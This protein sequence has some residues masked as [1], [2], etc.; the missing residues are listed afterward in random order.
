[1]EPADVLQLFWRLREANV[2]M[3]GRLN[4]EEW[5]RFGWH[6]ERGMITVR[7]LMLHMAGHDTNH[8]NQIRAILRKS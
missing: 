7:G 2:R 4:V 3:L 6:A 5:H 8:L 1:M